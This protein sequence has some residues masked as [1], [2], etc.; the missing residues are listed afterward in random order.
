MKRYIRSNKYTN[1]SNKHILFDDTIS[2]T[3]DVDISFPISAATGSNF[4]R[5]PGLDQFKQDVLDI[6]QDEYN[7]DV[8]EDVYDGILQ[9]GYITNRED[10]TSVYFNTYYDLANAGDSLKRLGVSTP[11]NLQPGLVFCFIHL[12]FSDHPLNDAGDKL[13]R[14]FIAKTTEK[15]MNQRPDIPEDHKFTDEEILVDERTMQLY[16]NEA[17]DRLKNSLDSRIIGWVSWARSHNWFNS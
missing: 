1:N 11:Y 7:F 12:R 15:Y 6:L 5:F 14:A 2:I 13:H 3:I 4:H 8:I 16:Y 10:G 17:I 9:K